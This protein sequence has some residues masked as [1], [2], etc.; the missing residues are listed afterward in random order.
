MT[1][2]KMK[3][4]LPLCVLFVLAAGLMGCS[5]DGDWE[6]ATSITDVKGVVRL[7]QATHGWVINSSSENT[8]DEVSVYYPVNLESSFCKDGL[9]VLF[10]GKIME[11]HYNPDDIAGLREYRLYITQ[12]RIE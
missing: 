1:M 4:F 7:N 5:T 3:K 10:S 9:K 8:I 6:K 12:V 2:M 11:A